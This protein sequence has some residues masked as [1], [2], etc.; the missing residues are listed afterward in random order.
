MFPADM[1][2]PFAFRRNAKA[3]LFS[4]LPRGSWGIIMVE[5]RNTLS[6][7][8]TGFRLFQK[9]PVNFFFS[10][11]CSNDMLH[12]KIINKILK[13]RGINRRTMRHAPLTCVFDTVK[14]LIVFTMLIFSGCGDNAETRLQ[15]FLLKGNEQMKKGNDAQAMGYYNAALELDSCFADSWNN[16]GTLYFR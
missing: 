11:V 12:F 5:E 4:L 16:L 7:N 1:Q 8:R 15:R 3:L 9:E 2:L 13:Q 14:C 6:G 10:F